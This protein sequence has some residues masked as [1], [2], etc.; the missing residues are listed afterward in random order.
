[1]KPRIRFRKLATAIV[2]EEIRTSVPR[3]PRSFPQGPRSQR[4]RPLSFPASEEGLAPRTPWQRKQFAQRQG[5]LA[6]FDELRCRGIS[7]REAARQL[8]VSRVSI[9]RYQRRIIPLTSRCGRRSRFPVNQIPASIIRTV[10]DL[11]ASGLSNPSAW[12]AIGKWH[13]AGKLTRCPAALARFLNSARTIPSSLL[14]LTGITITRAEVRT[15]MTVLEGKN[16]YR[17]IA[18]QS[19][20]VSS[21]KSKPYEGSETT[22][23]PRAQ[24][25]PAGH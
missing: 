22:K 16:F 23:P 9:W 6:C 19:T 21:R 10:L 11:R 1:M 3:S 12:R 2:E 25:G 14:R 20:T 15:P 5:L 17:L 24:K 18:G 4:L 13:A 8:G 7:G